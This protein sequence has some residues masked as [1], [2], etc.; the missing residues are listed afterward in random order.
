MNTNSRTYIFRCFKTEFSLLSRLHWFF[1]YSAK[2]AV[3]EVDLSSFFDCSA[4]PAEREI[5]QDELQSTK[6]YIR[7]ISPLSNFDNEK[8][9]ITPSEF[10]SNSEDHI[11]HLRMLFIVKGCA[12][13]EEYLHRYAQYY[14]ISLGYVGD[15]RNTLNEIGK[16]IVKPASV[17]NLH[18]SLKYLRILLGCDFGDDLE[19]VRVAY[20]IRCV[21]CNV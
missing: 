18:E 5:Y 11:S 8:L 21:M 2:L 15:K 17:S 16:A 12:S 13:L 7:D 20:Q 4:K 6:T 3:R 10:N 1:E 14:A 19:S 9:H